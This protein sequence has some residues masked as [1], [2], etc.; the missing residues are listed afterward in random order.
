MREYY[1][2]DR[3]IKDIIKLMQ[4]A[5]VGEEKNIKIV[6]SALRVNTPI[7]IKHLFQFEYYFYAPSL[8]SQQ[9]NMTEDQMFYSE[10]FNY[11][12]PVLR[13]LVNNENALELGKII[14]I[15]LKYDKWYEHKVHFFALEKLLSADPVE[16]NLAAQAEEYL[17]KLFTSTKFI[18]GHY[19]QI[20]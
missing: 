10:I 5:K 17:S 15:S 8:R 4:A 16:P 19:Q 12:E 1:Y 18:L 11:L 20:L 14:Y 13:D 3:P 6:Q 2:S 7:D 9:A